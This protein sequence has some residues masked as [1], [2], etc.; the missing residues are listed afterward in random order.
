MAGVLSLR[1]C[2]GD[3]ERADC[4]KIKQCMG[5]ISAALHFDTLGD[6][7]STNP[8]LACM[9]WQSKLVPVN[10]TVEAYLD[11]LAAAAPGVALPSPENASYVRFLPGLAAACS[12]DGDGNCTNCGGGDGGGS[13]GDSFSCRPESLA[14]AFSAVL[15]VR[16]CSGELN[17]TDCGTINQCMP[18]LSTA[19]QFDKLGKEPSTNPLIACMMWQSRLVPNDA[20]PAAYLDALGRAAPGVALPSATDAS[21]VRFLPGFVMS[22]TKDVSGPNGGGGG[23]DTAGG[24]SQTGPWNYS[25]ACQRELEGRSAQC[26]VGCC[27]MV[28]RALANDTLGVDAFGGPESATFACGQMLASTGSAEQTLSCMRKQCA[29]CFGTDARGNK[30]G[31][32]FGPPSGAESNAGMG[33][34]Y[35]AGTC[36]D[37]IHAHC[38]SHPY[39]ASCVQSCPFQACDSRQNPNCPCEDRSCDALYEGGFNVQGQCRA[40]REQLVLDYVDQGFFYPDADWARNQLETALGRPLANATRE[41]VK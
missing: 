38:E 4:G 21:Y 14:S 23:G 28:T 8:L 19:L 32:M 16:N 15:T 35:G 30:D 26:G 25:K 24:G 31:G 39:E 27:D 2:T 36:V 13:G 29:G 3:V 7:P 17:T 10:A 6:E 41:I 1:N 22:C 34:G 33:A 37:S 5:Q 40:V 9:L 11:A 18:A 12:D 20:P